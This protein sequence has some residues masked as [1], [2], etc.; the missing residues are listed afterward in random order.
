MNFNGKQL[1]IIVPHRNSV[2]TLERLL[3]SIPTEES[4]IDVL[5][6]DD[7]SN[8]SLDLVRAAYPAV[9][10][11]QLPQHRKGA[12]A[13]RNFGLENSTSNW[14]LF[15][16]ADDYFVEGAFDKIYKYMGSTFD[17]IYFTPTSVNEQSGRIGSR[18]LYYKGLLETFSKTGSKSILYRYFVPWSK[19][20]SRALVEA[21]GI[22]F[23]EVP[24]SNDMNFSLKVAFFS[25]QSHVDLSTIYCVTEGSESLTKQVSLTILESRFYSVTRYNQFLQQNSAGNHQLSTNLQIWNIR[26]FGIKKVV[27]LVIYSIRNQMPLLRGLKPLAKQVLKDLR[28]K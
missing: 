7:N 28:A 12:G 27:E 17:A 2:Q 8:V 11:L 21:K 23:D 20:I 1:S 6:V 14:L 5:V 22:T 19:L 13:A 25:A 16:D 26:K 3:A 10:F 24:A 4:W 9:R 18:H 15:S